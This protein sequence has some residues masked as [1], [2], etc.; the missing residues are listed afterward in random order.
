MEK[1]DLASRAA[2]LRREFGEDANSPIDIYALSL[3]I[4]KLSIFFYPLGKRISGMCIKCDDSCVIAIN[5]EM[6]KGRQ[7]FS[8]SHELYHWKY[9]GEDG[10]TICSVKLSAKNDNRV[11]QDADRFAS[12]LL[13][14]V[15]SYEDKIEEI[16]KMK[17]TINRED[18]VILEQRFGLSHQAMLWRLTNDGLITPAENSMLK[19]GIISTARNLGYDDTL[20][21][22]ISTDKAERKVY[23]QYIQIAEELFKREKISRGKYIEL[24]LDGFRSDIVYGDEEGDLIDD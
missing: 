2:R 23:G 9:G 24:L 17:T 1:I 22:P 11:E 14:P 18:L 7:R 6:S 16:L 10:T 19:D 20:Y 13:M 21:R 8:L 12:Y 5:S 3:M 15:G 4:P